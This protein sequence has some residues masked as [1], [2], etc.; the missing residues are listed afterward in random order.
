M[1][2]KS[3]NSCRKELAT[4][5]FRNSGLR[6]LRAFSLSSHRSRTRKT[7]PIPPSPISSCSWYLAK[8][9]LFA[10]WKESLEKRVVLASAWQSHAEGAPLAGF[11]L[12]FDLPGVVFDKIGR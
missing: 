3:S 11:T 10:I 2:L 4:A 9:I 5:V 1:F 12:H 8:K 7:W 6:I